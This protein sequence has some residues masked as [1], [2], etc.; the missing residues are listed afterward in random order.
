M[1]DIMGKKTKAKSD[2]GVAAV[3]GNG[4]VEIL[5]GLA[6]G[7]EE[8]ECTP[9]SSSQAKVKNNNSELVTATNE[10]GSCS[11][12]AA[13]DSVLFEADSALG[14]GIDL[15]RGT[16]R[17]A[18]EETKTDGGGGKE[19]SSCIPEDKT[20]PEH[21]DKFDTD[22]PASNGKARTNGKPVLLR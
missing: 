15:A 19:G 16:A 12:K 6:N 14:N 9:T 13:E 7:N 17:T 11:E 8:G 1:T 10:N 21:A 2:D 20:H 22:A 4:T 18:M 3:N 5:P